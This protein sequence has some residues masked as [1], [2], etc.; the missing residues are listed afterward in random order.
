MD[1]QSRRAGGQISRR[2]SRACP[3]TVVALAVTGVLG[4]TIP[5][6]SAQAAPTAPAKTTTVAST[7]KTTVTSTVKSTIGGLG[8][9]ISPPLSLPRM[10]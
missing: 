3:R 9:L 4:G 1:K 2:I 10:R 6:A 8:I 5:L 7:A